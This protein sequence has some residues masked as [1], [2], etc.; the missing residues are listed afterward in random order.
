MVFRLCIFLFIFTFH[1][2]IKQLKKISIYLLALICNTIFVFAQPVIQWQNTIGGNLNDYLG[3]LEQT[4]DGGY[5]LGGFSESNI[6][7]DKTE[8]SMGLDDYWVVKVDYSGNIQ[9]Q[10]T[11]GGSHLDRIQTVSR[12]IDGGYILGGTSRSDSSG[13]KTE[14]NMGPPGT[15]DY[16]IVKTNSIGNIQWQNTIG[17]NRD[18]FL[19]SVLQTADGGYIVGGISQSDSSGD[20]TENNIDTVS[21]N[22]T[23]DYWVLKLNSV[24][25]IQW[26]NA[27]GGTRTDVLFYT[28]QTTDGGYILGGYSDSDISNDKTENS[29]GGPGGNPDYWVVK[30]DASGNIQWQ[31]TIGG[32]GDDLLYS[33]Q[34]TFDGGYILGGPSYSLTSGDKTENSWGDQDYWIVKI[35]SFGNIQWQNDIGG[36]AEDELYAIKQSADGGY[37]IGGYSLSNISGD[38]TENNCSVMMDYWILKLDSI[39]NI[40]WQNTI[41]GSGQDWFHCLQPTLDG[42]YIVGGWSGSN[43]SCDKTENMI[44]AGDYWIIK[45]APDSITGILNNQMQ[46]FNFQVSPNP[47]NDILNIT[48]PPNFT[49]ALF[50]LYDAMGRI[51]IK[52]QDIRHKTQVNIAHLQQGIY[53]YEVKDKEGNAVYGKVVKQ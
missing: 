2:N 31:N 19:T 16:W 17:G 46:N 34:Q 40:K 53:F 9:W 20:K 39:G 29:V 11:I 44:G 13:D 48:S 35:D 3:S 22:T 14:N 42:G 24:G 27:I 12:T 21:P 32:Y 26:Q 36:T 15:E 7:G 38:K 51:S 4:P 47:T 10:N 30:L 8:N 5:I 52:P 50:I 23:Y 37:I 28:Q 41:G 18:D 6:S 33:L 45:L 1:F 25:N 43:I 49:T